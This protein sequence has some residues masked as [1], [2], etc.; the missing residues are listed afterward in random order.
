MP[1]ILFPWRNPFLIQEREKRISSGN[2]EEVTKCYKCIEELN[3]EHSMAW[4]TQVEVKT[5]LPIQEKCKRHPTW[6]LYKFLIKH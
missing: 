5:G 6:N 1:T 2:W 3:A 4:P